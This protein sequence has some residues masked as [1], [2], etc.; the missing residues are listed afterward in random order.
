MPARA[1]SAKRCSVPRMHQHRARLSRLDLRSPRASAWRLCAHRTYRYPDRGLLTRNDAGTCSRCDA[2]LARAQLFDPCRDQRPVDAVPSR[3]QLH[4]SSRGSSA[5]IVSCRA[6]RDGVPRIESLSMS[7]R[8]TPC[9]AASPLSLSGSSVL[10]RLLYTDQVGC[11][12]IVARVTRDSAAR[13]SRVARNASFGSVNRSRRQPPRKCHSSTGQAAVGCIIGSGRRAE[14]FRSVAD[15][16]DAP[17]RSR[18]VLPGPSC[19]QERASSNPHVPR[20]SMPMASRR[21]VAGL[22]DAASIGSVA[23]RFR[24]FGA[25]TAHGGAVGESARARPIGRSRWSRQ[26]PAS[27]DRAGAAGAAFVI[28]RGEPPRPE[29]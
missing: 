24:S 2:S 8:N 23:S 10:R 5:S 27:P 12:R 28:P 14:A 25:R 22:P 3:D 19:G 26:Q 11:H 4:A 20:V 7:T 18:S 15:G 9:F 21:L 1:R 6:P 29:A 13:F 16:G 17:S